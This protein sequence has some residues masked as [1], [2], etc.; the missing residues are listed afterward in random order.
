MNNIF[1][2]I[3]ELYQQDEGWQTVLPYS[4]V[5][6]Y[7]RTLLWQGKSDAELAEK[8]D[9]ITMY[10]VYLGNG[11][12]MAGD[13]NCYDF[14]DC[15]AWCGR[16]I[17]DFPINKDQ[18]SSFLGT[19]VEL[20]RS[21]RQQKIVIGDG[22][23]G[24]AL[25]KLIVDGRLQHLREDGTF[26]KTYSF[27]NER[28]NVDLERKVF[29]RFTENID[30]IHEVVRKFFSK[31][32]YE[33]DIER[34]TFFFTGVFMSSMAGE[35]PNSPE[36]SQAFWDYFIYDYHL[37]M[38]DERPIDYFFEYVTEHRHKFDKKISYDVLKE[39]IQAELM[40]FTVDGTP[41]M[42]G[43]Y[44]CTNV[45]T[46][47]K[48]RLM[49]PI[50]GNIPEGHIVFMGHIFYS[51]TMVLNFIRGINMPLSSQKRLRA[52]VQHAKAWYEVKKDQEPTW[53]NF[54]RRNPLV[55]RHGVFTF[56]SFVRLDNLEIPSYMQGYVP[57]ETNSDKETGILTIIQTCLQ[58]YG[59]SLYDI[60]CC[61]QVWLDF[62]QAY[63]KQ[64]RAEESW[65]AGVA[66]V[67]IELNHVYKYSLSEIADLF[68]G[69]SPSSV[70][71]T[72]AEIKNVLHIENHDPRY[73]SEDGLV[74]MLFS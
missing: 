73:L 2:Q 74:V 43:M 31:K 44:P 45:L 37:L 54:V 33:A 23:P 39:L 17:A 25:D 14:M 53:E 58:S 34:A 68:Y 27:L 19:L 41:D 28:S 30:K 67:Y 55:V 3:A 8:W 4:A 60:A 46:D 10:F 35:N 72:A 52:F 59:F 69:V 63:G 5:E 62:Y 24:E 21:L 71:R 66:K 49:L 48:I 65:A 50:E 51:G 16:N 26:D 40:V 32:S 22:A 56:G 18:V 61:Q 6:R 1:D 36:F 47:Q 70:Q 38:T 12:T 42:E 11:E 57:A 7:F 20:Y 13:M 64:I 9:Y 29:L 15:V